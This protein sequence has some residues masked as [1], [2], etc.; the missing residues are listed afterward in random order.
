MK[1]THPNNRTNILNITTKHVNQ[2]N[3]KL[4]ST[5]VII[6]DCSY[7]VLNKINN[8][9]REQGHLQQPW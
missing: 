9:Y 7:A 6:W 3:H 5:R 2:Q 4:L 8:K 1:V